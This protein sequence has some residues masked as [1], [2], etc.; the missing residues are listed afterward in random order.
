MKRR[1]LYQRK[2]LEEKG[3]GVSLKDKG[4]IKSDTKAFGMRLKKR[5]SAHCLEVLRSIERE[6]NDYRIICVFGYSRTVYYQLGIVTTLYQLTL[7]KLN[8]A[9]Q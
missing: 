2:T 7:S 9:F 1:T 6:L 4:S 8:G 3:Q 5:G